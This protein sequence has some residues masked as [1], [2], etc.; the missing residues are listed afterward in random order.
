MIFQL[1]PLMAG[2]RHR[3]AGW[4]SHFL[5]PCLVPHMS[6]WCHGNLAS[7]PFCLPGRL[8]LIYSLPLDLLRPSLVELSAQVFRTFQVDRIGGRRPAAYRRKFLLA[9]VASKVCVS[10]FC[11][12]WPVRPRDLPL[13]WYPVEFRETPHREW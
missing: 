3:Y 2:V 12:N 10:P 9:I 11:T 13:P 4:G 5:P 1:A 7:G 8:A 6:S